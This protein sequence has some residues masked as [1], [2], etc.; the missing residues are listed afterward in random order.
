MT[1]R[2]RRRNRWRRKLRRCNQCK[3][4]W[5]DAG[6]GDRDTPDF[7]EWGCGKE[8]TPEVEKLNNWTLKLEEMVEQHTGKP[9]SMQWGDWWCR[10]APKCPHYQ[11]CDRT[12]NQLAQSTQRI[13]ILEAK[14][15]LN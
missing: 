11:G 10:V 4:F 1:I 7:P 9:Y 15:C 2:N 6:R 14:P 13:S 5:W 3:H 8:G 12:A